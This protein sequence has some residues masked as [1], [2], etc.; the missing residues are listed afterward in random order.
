[1]SARHTRDWTVDPAYLRL[2]EGHAWVPSMG[3][4][5]S[6]MPSGR[7]RMPVEEPSTWETAVGLCPDGLVYVVDGSVWRLT[8]IGLPGTD[9]IRVTLIADISV[10]ERSCTRTTTVSKYPGD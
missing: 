5:A 1:M 9:Q 2:Y 10:N 8:K 4:V 3:W 7:H 6:V